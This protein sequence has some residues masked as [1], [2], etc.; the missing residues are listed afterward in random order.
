[1]KE[2]TAFNDIIKVNGELHP[3]TPSNVNEFSLFGAYSI[4]DIDN[5]R[6][7][8]HWFCEKRDVPIELDEQL[9]EN[10]EPGNDHQKEYVNEHFTKEEI[11]ELQ[12]YLK[13]VYETELIPLGAELPMSGWS[14]PFSAIGS[15][16]EFR[17]DA[18]GNI[19]SKT[20]EDYY[21]LSEDEGYSLPFKVWG[22]FNIE[23]P[24]ERI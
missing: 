5:E 12:D 9:I 15:Y 21:I 16:S 4:I 14:M 1:M 7:K 18:E 23:E 22:Y 11:N 17:V 24:L 2:Y 10:Y 6:V 8:V 13:R 20:I 19:T 3:I